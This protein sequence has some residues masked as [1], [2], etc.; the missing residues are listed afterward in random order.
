[1]NSLF[2]MPIFVAGELETKIEEDRRVNSIP[3]EVSPF[4][5]LKGLS[6]QNFEYLIYIR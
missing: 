4:E 2:D 1:M 6:Q 5:T 3:F